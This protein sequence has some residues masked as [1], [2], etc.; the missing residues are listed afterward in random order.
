MA[1]DV[2]QKAQLLRA[3]IEKQMGV[4]APSLEQAVR[5]AGRRLPRRLRKQAALW[6]EAETWAAHPKLA[7]RIDG[8]PLEQAYQ[9]LATHLQQLDPAEERKTR[10]LNTLAGIVLNL[11]LF[12]GLVSVLLRWRELI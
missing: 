11:L 12:G 3:M 2:A 4:S 5:R 9:D 7:R 1:S 8:P 6:V 10:R